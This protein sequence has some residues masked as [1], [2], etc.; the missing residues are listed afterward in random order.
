MSPELITYDYSYAVSYENVYDHVKYNISTHGGYICTL[1]RECNITAFNL[2]GDG[3]ALN[4][5]SDATSHLWTVL[6]TCSHPQPSLAIA[7][8]LIDNAARLQ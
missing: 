4:I 3:T 8:Y 1:L 7:V 5:G 2:C 6:L